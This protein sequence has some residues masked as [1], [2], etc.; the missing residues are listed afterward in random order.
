M[1]MPS[2]TTRPIA[3]LHVDWVAIATAT[4]ALSPS[5]VASASGKFATAPIRMVMTPATIAVAAAIVGRLDP[6]PGPPPRK[7]P[8]ESGTKPRIKGLSTMM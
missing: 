1:A 6:S 5:P 2:S 3:S 7:L 4:N 8:S